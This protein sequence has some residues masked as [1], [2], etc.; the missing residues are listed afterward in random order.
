MKTQAIDDGGDAAVPVSGTAPRRNLAGMPLRLL[1]RSSAAPP[2]AAPPATVSPAGAASAN[3]MPVQGGAVDPIAVVAEQIARSRAVPERQSADRAQSADRTPPADRAPL[4]DRAPP[5]DRA[6]A[7]APPAAAPAATPPAAAPAATPPAAAP[8]AARTEPVAAVGTAL[9]EPGAGAAPGAQPTQRNVVVGHAVVMEVAMQVPGRLV[10]DGV[11]S[12]D[13][14]ADDIV[15]RAGGRLEGRVSCRRAEISGSFT[16]AIFV[17]D[18]LVIR[19]GGR[20]SGRLVYG[21]ALQVETGAVLNG[22]F[23]ASEAGLR[24]LGVEPSHPRG[25]DEVAG[26]VALA[27]GRS[28]IFGRMLGAIGIA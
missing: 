5:A 17:R 9:P 12:G 16:G 3:G 20:A 18:R 19:S 27:S 2:A 24:K 6:A 26:E 15:V 8:A 1:E 10:I 21:N 11:V 14:E 4:A 23:S 13:I 22:C 7:L 28:S 25:V